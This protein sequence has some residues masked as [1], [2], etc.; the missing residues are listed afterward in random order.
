[1]AKRRDRRKN[2]PELVGEVI[3]GPGVTVHGPPVPVGVKARD[4]IQ[5]PPE[6]AQ[7]LS[8]PIAPRV[9]DFAPVRIAAAVD[10]VCRVFAPKYEGLGSVL[11]AGLDV[12][13]AVRARAPRRK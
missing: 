11:L 10:E 8:P 2:P 4:A 9:P 6:A 13:E 3:A 7:G 12:L 5:R 1:M